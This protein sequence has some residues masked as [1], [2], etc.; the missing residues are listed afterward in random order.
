MN[1]A[2]VYDYRNFD[3]H[4]IQ[5][6][7]RT[8][9][10]ISLPEEVYVESKFDQLITNTGFDS[11]EEWAIASQT[12]ALIVIQRDT[13]IYEKYFNGFDRDVYFHSQSMANSCIRSLKTW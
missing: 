12:T 5:G 6:A 7:K 1:V 2:D 13:L 11:F 4:R 3:N 10:F 9:Q 8:N